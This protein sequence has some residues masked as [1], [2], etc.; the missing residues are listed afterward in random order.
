MKKFVLIFIALLGM[1][2]SNAQDLIV[3]QNGDSIHCKI[4]KVKSDFIYFLFKN[5]GRYESTVIATSKV[6]NYK[7][8]HRPGYKIPKDSLPGYENFP[9]HVIGINTG[10]SYDPIRF[11]E[12]Q[13]I[14]PDDFVNDLRNGFHF[15]ANYSFYYQK[16]FGAGLRINY[17]ETNASQNEV[18]GTNGAGN[19][20]SATLSNAISVFYIGPSSSIRVLNNNGKNAFLISSS[21]GYM[22]YNEDYTY[23]EQRTTTVDGV[24]ISVSLGYDFSLNRN[25]SL[26]IQIASNA[27][28][29]KKIEINNGSG[30]LK[31]RLGDDERLFGGARLDFSLGL[32]YTFRRP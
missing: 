4:T 22:S 27:L 12:G 29:S 17:Y 24:G 16:G 11:R 28:M 14:G 9:R 20:I 30:T 21:I 1:N 5:K 13:S 10:L 15:E 3:S 25:L 19:P 26:G 32:R 8:D 18:A 6:L 31:R 2:V 7:R 23:V